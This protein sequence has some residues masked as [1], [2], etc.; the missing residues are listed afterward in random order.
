MK[1]LTPKQASFVQYAL[2]SNLADKYYLEPEFGHDE[3]TINAIVNKGYAWWAPGGHYRAWLTDE[4]N[5]VRDALS[6]GGQS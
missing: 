2:Y 4:G 5:A 1:K 3:R 6:G